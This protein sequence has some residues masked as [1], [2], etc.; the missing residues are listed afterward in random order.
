MSQT[1][2]DKLD[3]KEEAAKLSDTVSKMAFDKH[4]DNHTTAEKFIQSI[5]CGKSEW[6]KAAFGMAVAKYNLLVLGEPLTQ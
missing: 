3:P 5:I 4:G 2:L 1:S 6:S